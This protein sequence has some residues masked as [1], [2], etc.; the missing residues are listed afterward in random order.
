MRVTRLRAALARPPGRM[1][2]V[3]AGLLAVLVLAAVAAPLIAPYDPQ[4][5]VGAPFQAPSAHH[6][7]GTNDVGQD[8]F[9]QLLWGA[10]A[11]LAVA[12]AA[13]AASVALGVLVGAVAGLLGGVVDLLAMRTIDVFLAVPGLPLLILVVALVGPGRA[14]LV[15]VIA[16]FSWPWTARVV[17]SQ[18]LTLRA[19]GFV[20][21]A[22]GFGA[23]PAHL[24]RHHLLPVLAPLT[25]AG[26]VEVAGVAV[27]LDAGLAFLGLA[28][29]TTASW[30]LML[31]RAV[32]YPGIYLSDAWTWWVLPPGLAVTLAVLALTYLG[33]GLAGTG[34]PAPTPD[35]PVRGPGSR[36]A[37]AGG[38][39]G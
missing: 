30:G 34:R 14:T 25:A 17:R 18:V 22:A 29:P 31:N 7:L 2:A 27:V 24:L 39:R 4:A 19:R 5:P 20:K 10:R 26:F 3:G 23:G 6:W 37:T 8:V 16:G 21:A 38:A 32:T 35:G 15:A 33:L 36:L 11:A 1:A 12:L 28:D 9:S 13:A